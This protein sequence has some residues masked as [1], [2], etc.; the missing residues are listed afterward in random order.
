[1]DMEVRVE[2]NRLEIPVYHYTSDIDSELNIERKDSN[3]NELDD[4]FDVN[5]IVGEDK[6]NDKDKET[7][8]SKKER[9]QK[10]SKVETLRQYIDTEIDFQNIQKDE[11]TISAY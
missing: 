6:D 9:K 5:D 7:N 11:L 3:K 1:M 2:I 10:G 8:K 4:T